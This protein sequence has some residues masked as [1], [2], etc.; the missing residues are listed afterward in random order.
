MRP[1]GLVQNLPC[2]RHKVRSAL[3]DN[4]S[5]YG[6]K[7][8]RNQKDYSNNPNIPFLDPTLSK[9]LSLEERLLSLEL[10]LKEYVV[11]VDNIINSEPCRRDIEAPPEN[12]N[13]S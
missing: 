4:L 2:L 8:E 10:F 9:H 13:G 1:W 7:S 5:D 6:G 12:R 11:T 3:Y